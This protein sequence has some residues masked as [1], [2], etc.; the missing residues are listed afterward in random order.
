MQNPT[1]KQTSKSKL[2]DTE[3]RLVTTRGK[4]VG[5][6]E[7]GLRRWEVNFQLLKKKEKKI[8]RCTSWWHLTR[9]QEHCMAFLK[10]WILK[11]FIIKKKVSVVLTYL[12]WRPVCST[13]RY[14]IKTVCTWNKYT[15]TSIILQKKI[16]IKDFL[17]RREKRKL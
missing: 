16:K 10:E 5:R 7:T 6:W 8:R 15:I 2:E 17:N 1:I 3:N 9:R 4:G 14:Q 12:L 11:L 13:Y